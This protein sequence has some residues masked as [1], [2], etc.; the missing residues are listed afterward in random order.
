MAKFN[1][2]DIPENKFAEVTIGNNGVRIVQ[3]IEIEKRGNI[4]RMMPVSIYLSA[5]DIIEI[6]AKFI[7]GA[8]HGD[9]IETVYLSAEVEDID[10]RDEDRIIDANY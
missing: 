10:E 8:N 2:S 4:S 9:E 1:N 3:E 7:A 6:F 5:E